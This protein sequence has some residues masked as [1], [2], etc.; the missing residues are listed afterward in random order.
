MLLLQNLIPHGSLKVTKVAVADC[1]PFGGPPTQPLT[2]GA[3]Q[4]TMDPGPPT[5]ENLILDLDPDTSK[6]ALSIAVLS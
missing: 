5:L 2:R 3:K 6:Q 4:W 1:N